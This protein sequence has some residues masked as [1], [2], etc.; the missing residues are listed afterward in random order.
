MASTRTASARRIVLISA[1][2]VVVA[3]IAFGGVQVANA[4]RTLAAPVKHSVS[5]TST[6]PTATA[7]PTAAAIADGAVLTAAQATDIQN[8]VSISGM[9]A[10]QTA[11]GKLLAVDPNKPV[12]A[13][14]MQDIQVRANAVPA[15]TGGTAQDV[16]TNDQA[17]TDLQNLIQL[18]T[19]KSTVLITYGSFGTRT[20][21]IRGYLAQ[22]T[23][24]SGDNAT[25]VSASLSTIE[26][27]AKAYVAKQADPSSWI[28][29]VQHR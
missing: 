20:G 18:G 1:S 2:V 26:A 24:E 8:G 21:A 16:I 28:I 17:A 22:G 11:S 29:V 3:A 4:L 27:E 10:Y 14:V 12:P 7:T 9:I 19:G 5:L 13:A 25:Y 6:T 15:L 23:H